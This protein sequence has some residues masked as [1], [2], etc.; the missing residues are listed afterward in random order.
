MCAIDVE[1]TG[2]DYLKNEIIEI[3]IVP[4]DFNLKPYR[5]TRFKY[6]H[7]TLRPDN[8]SEI[9]FDAVRIAKLSDNHIDYEDAGL[10]LDKLKRALDEGIDQC[11]A[12]ELCLEWFEKL[13]LLP[14]KRIIPLAHNWPFDRDFVRKWLT[15]DAFNYIFDPRFRDTLSIAGYFNDLSEEHSENTV[16]FPKLKL[17]V[18]CARYNVN[19]GTSHNALDDAV[20]TA[21]VYRSMI[22]TPVYPVSPLNF[23]GSLE[24]I[25]NA[26]QSEQTN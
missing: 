23:K 3:A 14:K 12:A 17:P 26:R 9:D 16:P 24:D 1:T 8:Y 20:A 21:E 2:L 10:S 22:Y 18:L 11:R 5:D 19:R 25:E 7:A 15:N 6:F 4:L 13:K